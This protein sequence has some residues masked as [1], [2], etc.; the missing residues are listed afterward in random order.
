MDDYLRST[1][2]I[3]ADKVIDL[4]VLS[5]AARTQRGRFHSRVWKG[6]VPAHSFWQLQEAPTS[7]PVLVSFPGFA[8][9]QA[10]R[11]LGDSGC[12][13]AAFELLGAYREQGRLSRDEPV[14]EQASLAAYLD[15]IP[16][17]QQGTRRARRCVRLAVPGAWSPMESALTACLCMPRDLGGMGLPRPQLN[18]PIDLPPDIAHAVGYQRLHVDLLWSAERV[19]AEYQGSAHFEANGRPQDDRRRINALQSLGYRVLALAWEDLRDLLRLDAAA[20]KLASW[21]GCPGPLE[22]RPDR[23]TQAQL[24]AGVRDWRQ[25]WREVTPPKR[26]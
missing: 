11:D 15:L 17:S 5:P 19:V 3:P 25:H 4:E 12:L 24:M 1:G 23:G 9:V 18:A 10:A 14:C 22:A 21:L 8:L 6:L 7:G 2:A 20:D 16:L 26:P 13:G